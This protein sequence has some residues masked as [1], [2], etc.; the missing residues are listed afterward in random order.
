MAKRI[1]DEEMRFSIVVNGNEAQAELYKLEKS[2][3][4]LTA[5]NK[6][7]KAERA[8]LQAQ[9]KRGTEEYKRLSAE[10]KQNSTTIEA[11][12]TRMSALQKEIGVTGLTMSQLRKK[13]SALRLQLQHMVPGS[14]I[15]KK[16][17]ADLQAVNTRLAQLRTGAKATE[18]SL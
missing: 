12:R 8:K 11:N 13:A 4:D 17:E 14:S 6:A 9:G 3:R 7:L 1:V 5:S 15:Y 2:T 10:I 18:G 16:L